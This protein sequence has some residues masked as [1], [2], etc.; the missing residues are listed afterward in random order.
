MVSAQVHWFL[1]L[2]CASLVFFFQNPRTRFWNE[3]WWRCRLWK[4]VLEINVFLPKSPGYFFVKSRQKTTHTHT[5]NIALAG[6]CSGKQRTNIYRIIVL[7]RKKKVWKM[8][9]GKR[10]SSRILKC[11]IHIC[12]FF[13]SL[14]SPQTLH[15][16]FLMLWETL[17]ATQWVFVWTVLW[18]RAAEHSRSG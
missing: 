16:K 4:E 7:C 6:Y 10:N 17:F 1:A 15:M 2:W 18:A 3:V 8:H 12:V 14:I 11:V 13:L 5:K 9:E